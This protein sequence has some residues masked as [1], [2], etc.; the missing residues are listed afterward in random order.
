MTHTALHCTAVAAVVAA[1]MFNLP[2][3][4]VKGPAAQRGLTAKKIVLKNKSNSKYAATL[5]DCQMP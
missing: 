4:C 3:P 5:S 2:W 1:M